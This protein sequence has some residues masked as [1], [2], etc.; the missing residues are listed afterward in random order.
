VLQDVF[1]RLQRHVHELRD[2]ERFGP[3]LYRIV[4][5]VITDHHRARARDAEP[6]DDTE[7]PDETLAGADLREELVPCVAPLVARLPSPYREALTLVDLEGASAKEA[8]AMLGVSLTALKSRVQRG[9][10]KLRD[11]F[12]DCCRLELDARNRV[13]AYECRPGAAPKCS[14]RS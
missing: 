11:L 9:R 3:W 7:L 14:C 12:D 2:A 1:L 6:P 10:A 13:V 4:R 8:A 5:N